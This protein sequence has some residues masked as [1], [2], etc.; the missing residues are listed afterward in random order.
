MFPL[1]LKYFHI[2]HEYYEFDLC[3]TLHYIYY[4]RHVN[5]QPTSQR[6]LPEFVISACGQERCMINA[7]FEIPLPANEPAL[8]Y[9][10]GSRERKLITEELNRQ[11]GMTLDVPLIIGGQEV[12]TGKLGVAIC[13]HEHQHR[14]AQFHHAGEA[15]VHLAMQ[16]ALAAQGK[17]QRMPWYDRVAIFLRAA[18]LI[19]GKY[20][21]ILN[22]ATMLN[23]SKNV[24]QAEID[25]T[26][27]L[28]DFLRFNAYFMQKIYSE[29]PPFHAPG[30]WN[31]MQ[32]RPLE[33]FVFAVSPFNFTAIAG[34]LCIAPALM[35]NVVVWKPATTSVLSSYYLMKLYQEAGLP[36]GVINFVPGQGSMV[37]PI[38]LDD[39]HLAGLHVTCSTQAFSSMWRTIGQNIGKYRSYPR[40]VGET[41]GK[42]FV[43]L[44][45][46]ADI[47]SAAVALARGAFEYQGQKCS[48]VSRAYIPESLWPRLWDELGPMV[49]D[50]MADTGDPRDFKFFNAVISQAAFDK[51]MAYLKEARHG[52]KAQVLIG[53]GGDDRVGF[54]IQPT[55]ILTRDPGY[56]TMSEE[57]FAPVLTV[58]L[59]E[60]ERYEETLRI[61]DATS[62]YALTGAVFASDREAIGKALDILRHAAGNFYINDKPTGA[63]VGQQPFGGGRASGTN[64]K[65]GSH[66]NLLR[67]TNP[68]AIK[69][70]FTPPSDYRYPFMQKGEC[71]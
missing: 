59:Y 70:C 32:Y 42:D 37:A 35:G 9:A 4:E 1:L 3:N 44:H 29:Q 31:R 49:T 30:T 67:W 51:T 5:K 48:A 62:A 20:R 8:S 66:L 19:S 6:W 23:Q 12:R 21:F 11:Y 27:E 50:I 14:L 2:S 54:F 52:E 41:G 46:S 60:D 58:C 57:L 55:V 13:P 47:R 22:A 64:D 65:A 24:Y 16:A 45:P 7:M 33:G 18:D 71:S 68:Q 17:W 39:E 53:G 26:A 69:E 15:E 25:A 63:V 40:L 43:V 38:V 28:A 34:N 56:I 10:P 61:C 36:D